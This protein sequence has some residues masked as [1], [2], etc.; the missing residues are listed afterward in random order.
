MS[1]LNWN[2]LACYLLASTDQCVPI[3]QSGGPDRSLRE[4]NS[5]RAFICEWHV[6]GLL[7]LFCY[8]LV[9]TAVRLELEGNDRDEG[10]EEVYGLGR[11]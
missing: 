2:S 7:F 3:G 1:G 11:C 8:R 4:P 9:V 10:E 5:L 6:T